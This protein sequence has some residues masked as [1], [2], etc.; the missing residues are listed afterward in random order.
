MKKLQK[1]ISNPM[2]I[3]AIF[4][5]ISE[6]SAA[7]SLPFLDNAERE[8]Y[9]WFLISFPFYL[10]F[11]FFLTLN[12]NYRS[13]YAPSDFEKD[14]YFVKVMDDAERLE[15]RKNPRSGDLVGKPK[16]AAVASTSERPPP[17]FST[18]RR[19]FSW[20]QTAQD[21]PAHLNL[22]T[23]IRVQHSVNLPGSLKDLSIIDARGMHAQEDVITLME[24]IRRP[25]NHPT[26][27][28]VFLACSQS[29]K[30][31]K[32]GALK[33]STHRKKGAC[34]A[35][36]VVYNLNSQGVTVLDQTLNG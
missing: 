4:A 27:V 24:R 36:C 9:I 22:Q 8:I 19:G 5:A 1:K 10:L 26:K 3:I 7:V 29:E 2:T 30:L 32:E 18:H 13:L 20:F 25:R 12:F 23:S 34:E 15:N 16:T 17:G 6:T 35:F 33:Y 31:L 14:K 28:I 11:L 21:P